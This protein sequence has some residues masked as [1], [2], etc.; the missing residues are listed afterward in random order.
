M[1]GLRLIAED[2][3]DLEIIS[4]CMQDAVGQVGDL[5]YLP[6]RHRFALILNRFRW[7]MEEG[8]RRR[9]HQRVRA[10]LHF[11]TV[12]RAR[13]RNIAHDRPE[14]VLS[15]LAVRFEETQAPSGLV[16]LVFAGGGE[17]LLEVEAL[18][19]HLTDIGQNWETP[20][21]PSHTLD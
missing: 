16:T 17:I 18:D 7:E 15:L 1:S 3:Q 9:S 13:S 14:S 19:V 10:G 4:A 8:T 6:A 21:V 11:D 12:L 5:A 2:M 20:S